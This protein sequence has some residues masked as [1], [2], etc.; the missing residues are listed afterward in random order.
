MVDADPS[1]GA[2]LAAPVGSIAVMN[3][4]IGS[5]RK[6]GAGD[7]AWTREVSMAAIADPGNAGAIP[8]TQSGHCALTSAGAETRTLAIPTFDGQRLVLECTVYVGDI[9][10]TVASAIDPAGNTIITMGNAKDYIELVAMDVGG[11]LAWNVGANGGCAL[12]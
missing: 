2:G 12:T 7:T 3:T 4:G 6:S 5:W 9:V 1:A 10:T 11:A 8:V